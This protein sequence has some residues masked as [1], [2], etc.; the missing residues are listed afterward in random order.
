MIDLRDIRNPGCTLCKLHQTGDPIC[1]LGLGNK[2]AKIMVVSKMSNSRDW[3]GELEQDLSE[4]GID[5]SNV[6]F[7]QA[8]KCRTFDQNPSNADVKKCR[9]YLDQEIE[10]VQPEWILALGNEAL[11]ATTGKSGITKYRGRIY[12][13]HNGINV[14]PTISPSTA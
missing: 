13:G 7:T 4:V 12:G 8:I 2:R 1:Q 9:T 6:Y 10:A 11:L 14:V 5:T 3:Q